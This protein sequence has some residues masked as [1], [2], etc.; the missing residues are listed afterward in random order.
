M[1]TLLLTAQRGV[2]IWEQML[3][4]P[5]SGLADAS[6]LGAVQ[7]EASDTPR[8]FIDPAPVIDA[9][10]RKIEERFDPDEPAHLTLLKELFQVCIHP[11]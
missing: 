8:V 5:P 1:Q 9:I 3:C 10:Q 4:A 11:A 7:G 6:Q 2:R